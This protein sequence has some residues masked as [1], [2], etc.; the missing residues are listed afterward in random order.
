M[1][2][3]DWIVGRIWAGRVRS[4]LSL[5]NQDINYATQD[6]NLQPSVPKT[7]VPNPQTLRT[8]ALATTKKILS[9]QPPRFGRKT[10]Y[11]SR[12]GT[13]LQCMAKPIRT[14][15]RGS[16]GDCAEWQEWLD[17]FATFGATWF[18]QISGVISTIHANQYA[19]VGQSL[20]Q[21]AAYGATY[22]PD[23]NHTHGK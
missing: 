13:H 4:T 15:S 3:N 1:V 2:G 11:F 22:R 10:L 16:I 19:I 20:S 9:P 18:W 21:C 17:R 23:C 5:L 8:K 7:D 12:S 14:A 6:S